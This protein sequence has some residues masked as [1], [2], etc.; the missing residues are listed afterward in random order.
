MISLIVA[1]DRQRLI[2]S[3][4]KLPWHYKEDLQ[5]FKET[6]TGHDLMMGRKT[7]ESI[8]SYRNQPLPNRHHY[9]LSRQLTYEH[10]QVDIIGDFKHFLKEYPEEN[11]LFVIG[12][13]AVYEQ[14]LPFA[15]RLYVTHIDENHEGDTYF[16]SLDLSSWKLI[17]KKKSGKLTFSIYEKNH[18]KAGGY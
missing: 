5:Y 2:G 16:P 14:A 11:E 8:L 18:L 1:F 9:V 17:K 12:G 4:N 10:P 6:T 7:F 15:D 3:G 13:A